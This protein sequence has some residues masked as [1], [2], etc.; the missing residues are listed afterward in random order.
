MSFKSAKDG[1]NNDL[2]EIKAN[3]LWK[4]ERYINSDQKS[5]ITL[6]DGSEVINMCANNY[7]GLANNPQIIDAAK[8]GATLGEIVTAMKTVFG[9][10]QESSV[11]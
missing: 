5:A 4:T 3:G 7:L 1:L 2:E 11:F 6:S 10:W 9:E 8:K